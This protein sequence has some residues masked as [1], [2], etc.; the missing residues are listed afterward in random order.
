MTARPAAI[1]SSALGILALGAASLA[2]GAAPAAPAEPAGVG[3]GATLQAFAGLGVVLALIVAT[4]WFLKRLQPGR[5]GAATLLK[6]VASLALGT[7][8]RVV[9]VELG[10][11]WLVLGVTAQTI[12][13]LHT[14]EREAMPA[15]AAGSTPAPAFAPQLA[16]WAA[17]LGA[18]RGAAAPA[19]R[20]E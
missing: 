9:V 4:A 15:P 20:P 5:F 13:T 17:R 6:P 3:F 8:E 12:T 7:R 14:T 19:G 16:Q 11:K 18:G 1:A 2:W 10:D